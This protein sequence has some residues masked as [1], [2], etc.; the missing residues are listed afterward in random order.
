MTLF[1]NKSERVNFNI[2]T[3][4]EGHLRTT[5]RGIK[6][7][8]CPFDYVIYQ[9]I[10]AEVKPDLIIEIG[11]NSGG[12]ALY[13][14]DLLNN[15]GHGLVHSIDINDISDSIVKNHH[16]VK[17][18]HEGYQGYDTAQIKEFDKILVVED[19][20]HN[21]KDTLA[22]L[23]IFSP[24]VT[25]GSYFIVEDGIVNNLGIEKKFDG[26][27][28]RAINE[29]LSRDNNFEIDRKWCDFY[30]NNATFNVNGYL[31]KK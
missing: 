21:Y 15:I 20:S 28:L 7:I 5:Y 23:H 29:F 11:T 17:L 19:G 26:G 6:A 8:R 9:M 13:L 14:A 18:F 25:S 24:F 10:I 2:H 22:A 4:Y 12:G 16:R 30:G 3:I 27:P 1:G 31:R